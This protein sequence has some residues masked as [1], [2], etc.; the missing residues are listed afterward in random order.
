[1][2]AASRS[3]PIQA[4]DLVDAFGTGRRRVGAAL[5]APADGGQR[6]NRGG[7]TLP[8]QE[9]QPDCDAERDQ[10]AR[11]GDERCFSCPASTTLRGH[12]DTEH[13]IRST[14]T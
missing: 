12:G 14:P 3:A 1:V 4:G 2:R 11:S 8:E 7:D 5:E 10:D 13:P 9:G 6:R